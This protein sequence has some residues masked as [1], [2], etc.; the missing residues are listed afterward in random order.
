MGSLESWHSWDH[1][2]LDNHGS[3]KPWRI[4]DN[5]N[6]HDNPDIM[7]S[8]GIPDNHDHV[9]HGSHYIPGYSWH[10]W[11]LRAESWESC[12]IPDN[13]DN[14]GCHYIHGIMRVSWESLHPW[15]S[16][17]S[18]ESWDHG[19][20]LTSLGVITSLVIMGISWVSLHPCQSSASE[21]WHS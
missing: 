3:W 8:W 21:S 15:Q 4:P 12:H 10:P 2:S 17:Q 14:H 11:E 13:P 6:S 19:I 7:G 16:W 1:G 9:S 5:H 18:S 20:F